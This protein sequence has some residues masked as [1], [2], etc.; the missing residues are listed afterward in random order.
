LQQKV[1]DT[2]KLIPR[3]KVSTY[4]AVAE[5][6]GT[7]AVRAVA[8]AVGKNPN[9][10]QVPCHRVLP[11]TGNI[12]KYSGIG[13]VKTKKTLLESEGIKFNDGKVSNLT[14]VLYC[15]K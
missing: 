15:F 13:G 5:Y 2:L 11:V 7:K 14:D 4:G 12:G 1:W 10:P 8:S 6:L 3:G 9:A